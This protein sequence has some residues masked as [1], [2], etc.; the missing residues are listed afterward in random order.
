[1]LKPSTKVKTTSK[2]STMMKKINK[3]VTRIRKN[4][5]NEDK[6]LQHKTTKPLTN[7]GIRV[8]TSTSLK[9]ELWI[10]K[11]PILPMKKMKLQA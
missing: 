6:F 4:L 8:R 7:R 9:K 5:I 1:M 10:T 3:E 11:I 2:T